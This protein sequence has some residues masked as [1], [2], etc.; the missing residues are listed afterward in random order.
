MTAVFALSLAF[1]V[2]GCATKPATQW[3]RIGNCLVLYEQASRDKQ[4]VA[5]G[6]GCD[7]KRDTITAQGEVK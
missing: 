7:I 6:Q 4:L 2:A 3:W 1:V 5:I